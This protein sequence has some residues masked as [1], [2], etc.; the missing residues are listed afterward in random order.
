MRARYGRADDMREFGL[1]LLSTM[2]LPNAPPES[3]LSL[4]QLRSLTDGSF[5][6]SDEDGM[7]TDGVDVPALRAFLDADSELRTNGVGGVEMLDAGSKGKGGS[8]WDLLGM[9]LAAEWEDRPSATE[10]LQHPFW[11]AEMLL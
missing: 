2:L 11:S 1:L 6:A 3:T 7:K 8:G 9:L 5:A 4:L 10:A